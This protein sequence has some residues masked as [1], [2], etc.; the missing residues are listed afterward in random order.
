M[1]KTINFFFI[2]MMYANCTFLKNKATTSLEA[3]LRLGEEGKFVNVRCFYVENRNVYSFTNLENENGDYIADYSTEA[4]GNGKLYYNFCRDVVKTCP[5]EENAPPSTLI[6]ESGNECY[7]LSGPIDGSEGKNVWKEF[8]EQTKN[9]T[10]KGLTLNLAQGG[11]CNADKTARYKTIYKIY[12]NENMDKKGFKL[13]FMDF[14]PNECE[15][16]I[17]GEAYDAC[18]AN[19]LLR[20]RQFFEDNKYI[21]GIV[22]IVMGI[23]L[24]GFGAKIYKVTVVLMCGLILAVIVSLIVFSF[25]TIDTELKFWL[26]IGIPFVVGIIIGIFLLKLLKIT[27]FIQGACAGYP[28]GIFI[29]DVALKYI[30]WNP[31]VLYWIIIILAMIAFGLLALLFLKITIIISTSIIGGFM[32]IKGAS[33]FIGHFPDEQQ[34]IELIKAKEYEQLTD[35]LTYHTY[36]YL[37]AWLALTIAGICLQLHLTKGLTDKDF[38]GSDNGDKY[39]KV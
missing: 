16:F 6:F 18:Q 32:I 9:E 12:C 27:V 37:A 1:S 31:T 23:F 34:I 26:V 8:I 25:F 28:I 5:N 35:I 15:N 20:L 29:Y 2:I 11:Y 4:G 21:V 30:H 22:V 38:G 7:R 36:I 33:L 24:V 13:N 39:T 10:K 17:V 3:K 14:D 19:T